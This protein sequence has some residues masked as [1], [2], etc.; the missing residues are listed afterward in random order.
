M[1]GAEGAVLTNHG[2]CPPNNMY[3]NNIG[4][5][6]LPSLKTTNYRRKEQHKQLTKKKRRDTRILAT[7]AK[8]PGKSPN[9][10]EKSLT[11]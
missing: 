5:P 6:M 7:K 8:G 9:G 11:V 2:L 1:S 3:V 4:K 10:R